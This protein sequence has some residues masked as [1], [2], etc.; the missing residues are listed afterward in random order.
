MNGCTA[1]QS[2]LNPRAGWNTHSV[3]GGGG[4]HVEVL[5][6]LRRASIL[7][8]DLFPYFSSHS[9]EERGKERG[10]CGGNRG[11]ENQSDN[12]KQKKKEIA[13]KEKRRDGRTTT[14]VVKHPSPWATILCLHTFH[15]A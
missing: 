12:E 9:P 13:K 8:S 7:T 14:S 5:E 1:F 11:G 3:S 15:L 10:R 6:E 2:V 4:T